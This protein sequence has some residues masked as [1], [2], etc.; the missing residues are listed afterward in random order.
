MARSSQP[1]KSR[2]KVRAA[3][4]PALGAGRERPGFRGRGTPAVARCR[5]QRSGTGGPGVRRCD[6]RLGVPARVQ[7]TVKRGEVW[8]VAGGPEYAG[9]PRP[10]VIFQDDGFHRTTSVTICTF[11]TDTTDAPLF[12]LPV[13]P[14][15]GNGLRGACRLMVSKLVTVPR[16]KLGARLGQLAP[17]DL[18]RLNRAVV[19]PGDRQLSGIRPMAQP[20]R[21][22]HPLAP[23]YS[24]DTSWRGRPQSAAASAQRSTSSSSI[25]RSATSSFAAAT[26]AAA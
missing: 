23:A 14:S 25:S 20:N 8:T 24:S 21:P 26:T 18:M 22:A 9:K 12:R 5:R 6:L 16:R 13:Q 19:V 11:T 7:G 4:H 3:A 10:A 2:D 15:E 1:T 17:E